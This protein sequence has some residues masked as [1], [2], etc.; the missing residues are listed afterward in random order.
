[1]PADV[2]RTPDGRR[3]L[4]EDA[5]LPSALYL[6]AARNPAASATAAVA[7][8]A[9]VVVSALLWD[10]VRSEGARADEILRLSD[11]L[12]LEALVAD[13]DR[14]WPAHPEN[15]P[16]YEA[17]IERAQRIVGYLDTHRARLEELQALVV[18][19]PESGRLEARRPLDEDNALSLWWYLRLRRLVRGIEEL[20]DDQVGLLGGG[21]S[22]ERGWGMQKRLALAKRLRDGFAADGEYATRWERA[23]PAI[24]DHPAYAGLELA[25][26][27]GLAPIGP[28]PDSGLWEF[29]HL[30][31]GEE[32][33]RGADGRLAMGDQS[34]L[35]LVLLPAGT[36]WMGAQSGDASLPNYDPGTEGDESPVH[37]LTLAPFFLSKYE[38][39]QGQ[40]KR[41]AG[42]NPSGEGPDGA[43]FTSWNAGG[44]EATYLEPVERISWQ[45]CMQL[46]PRMG[47]TLPS[48]AQW[49]YGARGGTD[50]PWWTGADKE[51]LLG[52]ANLLDAYA[53][54]HG[55]AAQGGHEEWLDDG[56]SGHAPVDTLA[57]NGFGLHHVHGNVWEW[58]LDG[59]DGEFYGRSPDA[60]PVAPYTGAPTFVGRGGSYLN[61]AGDARSALRRG[62]PPSNA[63]TNL[64]VRPAL[65]VRR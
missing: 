38:M 12:L 31:S 27:M 35:V 18:I 2:D 49:E 26:Q 9:F 7:L 55:K 52:A 50:T 28:D 51:T 4:P 63:D 32:P 29:W 14:Y 16:H 59:F 48:E 17:W 15:I 53:L 5:V 19:S 24:R 37:A 44:R 33:L 3:G 46:L 45:D 62:G 43:H 41:F 21:I 25:P 54:A 23:I 61:A 10:A 60:D 47:L 13:A 20:T 34:G 40:W 57:A 64:G 8:I 65:R 39:S 42:R 30:G 6:W 56:Y 22:P 36:F 1:M 58:C 11:Q